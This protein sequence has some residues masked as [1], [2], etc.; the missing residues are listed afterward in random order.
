MLDQDLSDRFSRLLDVRIAERAKQF[1]AELRQLGAQASSKGMFNSG[2]HASQ[3]L[4]AHERE[5]EI[6]TIIA[7]ESL[8]R[9]HKTLGSHLGNGIAAPF[10][11]ALHSMINAFAVDLS[12]SLQSYAQRLPATVAMSL[13]DAQRHLVKKHDI[14]VDL[15]E[16]SLMSSSKDQSKSPQYN[17]YGSVGAVQTGANS[18]ANVVQ[19]LGAAD[20]AALV[21]ALELTSEAIRNSG[22]LGDRQQKELLEIAAECESELRSSSP[23]N[24]RLL[25]MFNVLA[26]SIQAVASAQPAYQALKVALLPLGVTLP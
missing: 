8:V 16:D 26:T 9:A 14:E 24:T 19:N 6:R 20:Q 4:Q 5:L 12:A 23:N 21:K 17:F 13:T 15:Y 7:W 2:Y 22:Q 1:P 3:V 18:Q 25:T 11:A 10:K